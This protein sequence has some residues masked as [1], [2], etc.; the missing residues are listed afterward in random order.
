MIERCV[1]VLE[2]DPT[3]VLAYG[4]PCP[5]DEH[6]RPIRPGPL[7]AA[8][9]RPRRG[10]ASHDP[11]TRYFV[12]VA[13]PAGHPAG[14]NFG[15]MRADALRQALPLGSFVSDDLPFLAEMT[16][17]GQFEHVPEV[18]Q[19]R[20]YHRGQGHRTPARGPNARAG[21]IPSGRRCERGRACAC[22]ASI[23]GPYGT[24]RR[25]AAS[26]SGAT[27]AR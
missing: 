2:R 22:C 4:T 14:L 27:A 17:R 1:A 26:D 6:G 16:L 25:I 20:R 19:Y 3:V 18:V 24:R 23:S 8:R 9:L 7:V 11:R 5:I 10:L 12:C 21:S 15:L 13:V